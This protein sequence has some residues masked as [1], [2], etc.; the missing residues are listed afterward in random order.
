MRIRLGW[1]GLVVL[2]GLAVCGADWPRWR[3]PANTGDV[4]AGERV[5]EALPAEATPAWRVAL[6]PGMSSPVVCSGRLFQLDNTDGRETV[7]ALDAATGRELWRV[8]FDEAHKDYQSDPGPRCTPTA[9]GDRVYVQSCRGEFRCLAADDGRTLWRLNFVKD[10]GALF[11]GETGP[12]SG[13]SRHGNTAAP[14]VEGDRI[15]VAVGG[16]TG[17]SVVCFDK[18][19]GK[20]VWRS[21]DDTPGYA[22]LYA[23]DLGGVHQ[24]LA[25]T[26]VALIGLDAASGSLLWRVP[27]KTPLGRHITT[28]IVAGDRVTV[29]SHEAGLMGLRVSRQ[30]DAFAAAV[31]WTSKPAAI[32]CSSPVWVGS[33]LYGIGPSKKLECVDLRTGGVAWTERNPAPEPLRADWAAFLVMGQ[34]VLMLADNGWLVLFE[35][36]PGAFR[37]VGKLKV[38]GPNWCHPAYADGRLYVRDDKE[39]LCVPL[40]PA[41][42]D[43]GAREMP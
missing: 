18:R 24:V 34:R 10:Y 25:Y 27:V 5:P 2:T 16:T 19:D 31:A 20:V 42:A 7:H 32:N 21:Q 30:G 14:L 13:A 22:P 15:Y 35:A 43:A 11:F 38:C 37:P 36:D 8:P 26:A 9:D 4:P 23:T 3:G 28:P 39:L 1:C 12:A 29:S 41:D 33:Y 6:G 17:A 40:V